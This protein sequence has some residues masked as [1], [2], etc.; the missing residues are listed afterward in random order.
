MVSRE[1]AGRNVGTRLAMKLFRRLKSGPTIRGHID[2]ID[3][4]AIL[5][6][7][8]NE[9][10]PAARL[11]VQ[12]LKGTQLV[13]VA[14]AD[15][16][17]EDLKD[18]GIGDGRHAFTLR[19][20]DLLRDG[21]IHELRVVTQQPPDCQVGAALP[22]KSAALPRKSNDSNVR[23]VL[24]RDAL[25]R[26]ALCGWAMDKG[27]PSRKLVVQVLEDSTVI[28]SAIANEYRKDLE[29]AGIGD[30][31]HGFAVPIPSALRDGRVINYAWSCEI[32][33]NSSLGS[34]RSMALSF[35]VS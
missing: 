6:W 25:H 20:S 3:D 18:A 27:N 28:A 16:Y 31:S 4:D 10:Q 7:V 1:R 26:G 17:R 21:N 34:S 32:N 33:R 5:G 29:E 15:E 22:Y 11:V 8:F 35:E 23:G 24:N 14:T 30:G 13:G 2:R 12:L 19:I 9:T